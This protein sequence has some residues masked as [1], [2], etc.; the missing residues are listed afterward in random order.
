[1]RKHVGWYL[2]GYPV[3]GQVRRELTTTDSIDRFLEVLATLDRSLEL[4]AEARDRPRGTQRGPQKVT[5]PDGWLTDRDS[6]A[7]PDRRAEALT[8]GG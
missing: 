1:V 7:P 4:P 2:A 3:G 5:L 8:S 6:E